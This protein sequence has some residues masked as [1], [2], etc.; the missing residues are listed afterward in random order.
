MLAITNNTVMNTGVHV[1]FQISI[2]TFFGYIHRSGIAA[3]W[4]LTL[5]GIIKPCN[6]L[7][8]CQLKAEMG[9]I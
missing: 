6:P 2:F 7:S 9:L 3:S 1:S 8:E 4:Q 5:A